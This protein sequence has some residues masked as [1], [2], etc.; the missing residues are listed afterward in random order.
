MADTLYL[1]CL[2]GLSGDMFLSGLLDLGLDAREVEHAIASLHLPE[3]IHL[4]PQ[5]Q[6]RCGISGLW[7]KVEI[8][9]HH[10]HAHDHPHAHAEAHLHPHSTHP[11]TGHHSHGRSFTEISQLLTRSAL[12][13]EVKAR[14]LAVFRRLGEVEA[15]IHGTTLDEVHFHEV[16]AVDSILDIVGV[17][18]GLHR[19]GIRRV[20]A[21]PL[22]DGHGTLQCAHGTFPVPA[23]ATLALLKG[24][25]L[26][27]IDIPH[28][29]ITP[30]GA[31]LLA[32]FAESFAPLRDFTTE[33]IAYGLGT[34]D[35]P[36]RPNV[37]R[38]LLGQTSP[39]PS[40][41]SSLPGAAEHVAIL[42]TNLDDLTSEHLAHA[43]DC[44]MEAGALDVVALPIVMKKGRPG[45]Q[46]QVITTVQE[47][48]KIAG[49]LLQH[50]TAAGLRW[51]EEARAVLPRRLITVTTSW[52][53]VRVKVLTLPSGHT[54]IKAEFEDCRRLAA[55][56]G[57]SLDQIARAAEAAARPLIATHAS[58]NGG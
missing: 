15:S 3:H 30:T 38:L 43:M 24:V 22:V 9:H 50:T 32:E 54:R 42:T 1:D 36:S 34:R 21:S 26:T 16:G 47:R 18:W 41:S 14:A 4:H 51:R 44:L 25:P 13:P 2:S 56:H 31:A 5:R 33:K 52:G 19:L 20:L 45:H 10:H 17:C 55:E 12:P 46:L 8:H 53:Q 40:A 27:Q 23:P 37:V 35:F 11:S 57:L 39:A 28:E 29:L 6:T 49:V 58:D 48:E 7:L